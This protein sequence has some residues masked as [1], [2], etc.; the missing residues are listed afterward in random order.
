MCLSKI[1]DIFW[2]N[3]PAIENADDG[4]IG[5][6][7]VADAYTAEGM[8]CW[9]AM[10][11]IHIGIVQLYQNQDRA[12]VDT[13][14]PPVYGLTNDPI[15]GGVWVK[16]EPY[17][18]YGFGACGGS[19][20]YPP[21]FHRFPKKENAIIYG[22]NSFFRKSKNRSEKA[23]MVLVECRVRQPICRGIQSVTPYPGDTIELPCYVFGEM[24][25]VGHEPFPDSKKNEWNEQST[26]LFE[27][28]ANQQND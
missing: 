19:V 15:L 20:G 14:Y 25:V 24:K 4:V 8:Q 5:A 18:L 27:S 6:S 1:V 12:S 21:G 22:A 10:F 11:W 2:P 7:P 16:A 23:R 3:P 9:G 26:L 13:Y 17:V 28:E